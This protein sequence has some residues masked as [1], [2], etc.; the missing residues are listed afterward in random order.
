M[1]VR[2]L[3]TDLY[4]IWMQYFRHDIRLRCLNLKFTISVIIVFICIAY[5]LYFV[6]GKDPT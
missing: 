2:E 1:Y 5:I 3:Q 4:H 6:S